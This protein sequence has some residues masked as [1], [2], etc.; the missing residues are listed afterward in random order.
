MYIVDI[1]KL[2]DELKPMVVTGSL[3]S[4]EIVISIEKNVVFN[5]YT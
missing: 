2:E 1:C 4:G 3:G 5:W